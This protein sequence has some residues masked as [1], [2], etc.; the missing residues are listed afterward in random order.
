MN[1]DLV[2][3][4][5][6][7]RSASG[8][9]GTGGASLQQPEGPVVPCKVDRLVVHDAPVPGRRDRDRQLQG[10]CVDAA[11][12]LRRA[13]A[14]STAAARPRL[15]ATSRIVRRSARR[16][17]GCSESRNA[18]SPSGSAA[19]TALSRKPPGRPHGNLGCRSGPAES[20]GA[21]AT[22]HS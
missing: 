14:P 7:S 6:S 2:R 21:T 4:E 16:S 19:R 22:S 1:S 10:G 15:A 5:N 17:D 13:Q 18:T 9:L 12:G 11:G 8:I 20:V 3:E